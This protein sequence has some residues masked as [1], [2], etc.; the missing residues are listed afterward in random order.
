VTPNLA[1]LGLAAGGAAASGLRLY[2]TVAALGFLQRIGAVHL[3]GRLDVLGSTPILVLASVLFLVEFLADK[4][5][6]V[7][8]AWDAIHTFIRIPAA[9]VLGFAALTDVAEPWRMAAALLCGTIA[10]SAHGLKAGTRLALNT[11]PEPVTNWAASFLED[12]FVAGLVW[13]I[14]FHPVIAFAVGVAFLA[15]GLLLARW[16]VRGVRRLFG[17]SRRRAAAAVCLFLAALVLGHVALRAARTW[18]SQMS[19]STTREGAPAA[20]VP[21]PFQGITSNIEGGEIN[22]EVDLRDGR[23]ALGP[24]WSL[25]LSGSPLLTM[26]TVA[27][28][29]EVQLIEAKIASGEI[30][31]AGQ[32]LRPKI[33]IQT[34]RF[35]RGKGIVDAGFRGKGIWGPI[36]E[37]FR[38]VAMHAVRKIRFK[39]DIPSLMRGDVMEGFVPVAGAPNAASPGAPSFLGL[40]REARTRH[41]TL[42]AY[43]GRV[44]AFE[45]RL[46]FRTARAGQPV[47]LTIE[48]AA[49]RPPSGDAPAA[50]EVEGRLDGEIE[51]GSLLLSGSRSQFSRGRLEAG[52]FSLRST[53]AGVERTIHV[54][55]MSLDLTSGR[56]RVPGGPLVSVEAPSRISM[57]DFTV[58]PD[59]GYSGVL[60][61]QWTGTV[62]SIQRAGTTVAA[63]RVTVRAPRIL[64]SDGKATGDVDLDFDYE[65]EHVLSVANPVSERAA[66]AVPL[67]FR[68]PFSAHLHLEKAGA[69]TGS[70]TGRYSLK[71]PWEIVEKIALETLRARWVFDGPLVSRVGVSLEPRRFST[72][73]G[74]CFLLDL[75][76]K[77][78]MNAGM[79]NLFRQACS[80]RGAANLVVDSTTRTFQLKNIQIES[81]CEGL[82]GRAVNFISPF[83]TKKYRD[84]V[85]FRMPADLPF[86]VENVQGA[87]GWIGIAGRVHYDVKNRI[88]KPDE[89]APRREAGAVAVSARS[90]H[91]ARVP[92]RRK[93]AAA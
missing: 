25:E 23:V 54:G 42:S 37:V 43:P 89:S 60:G 35:E 49:F 14:V 80:P 57:R 56:F 71:V 92:L 20:P 16:A 7:D 53:P 22:G 73:G 38:G 76:L 68:G 11:T 27:A 34:L 44:F 46:S 93:S 10:F 83:L 74:S 88:E 55:L 50:F 63:R 36:S 67:E 72:C 69:D 91:K 84:M 21:D 65:V 82:I 9:A 6:V 32:G 47:R 85:L 18:E 41:S 48:S 52:R 5:P 3:P 30:V 66:R 26:R 12:L 51:Q 2:G 4:I 24:G 87:P 31:I 90:R 13:T 40:L 77:A 33:Q 15:A 61:M 59:G 19:A 58:R 39:T 45:N 1:E 17:G 78:E 29:G 62:G 70:V 86:T 75:E 79:K 28:G 81:R 8:S 64:I